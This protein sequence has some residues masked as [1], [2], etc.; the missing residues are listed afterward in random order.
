MGNEKTKNS[1]MGISSFKKRFVTAAA[2]HLNAGN[3]Y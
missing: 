3:R 1:D 2:K